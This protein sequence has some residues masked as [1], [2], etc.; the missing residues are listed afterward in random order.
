MMMMMVMMMMMIIGGPG[1]RFEV[2]HTVSHSQ[3]PDGLVCCC[4]GEVDQDPGD[5]RPQRV[6]EVGQLQDALPRA[7]PTA[8][9]GAHFTPTDCYLEQD[10]Q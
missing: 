2:S 5:G 6:H 7:R 8:A 4:R 10:Q 3:W 9:T 1:F